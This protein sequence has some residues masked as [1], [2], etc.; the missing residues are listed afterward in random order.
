MNKHMTMRTCAVC[1]LICMLGA[2]VSCNSSHHYPSQLT[3]VDSLCEVRP[4]SAQ[5]LLQTLAKDT[6]TMREDARMYYKLLTIRA[7][8]KLYQPHTSDSLIRQLVNYYEHGGDPKLLPIAYYYAGSVYR[9][10]NDAPQALDY[11]QK[12]IDTTKDSIFND[13]KM[14]AYSQAGGLFLKQR[15]YNEALDM[16]HKAYHSSLLLNDSLK[17]VHALRFIGT[18]YRFKLESDSAKFYYEKALH[19][20]ERYNDSRILG[21]LYIQMAAYYNQ[22]KDYKQAKEY[23]NKARKHDIT[24]ERRTFWGVAAETFRGLEVID[25]ALYYNYK[26]VGENHLVARS[27]GYSNLTDIY[28]DQKDYPKAAKYI[29]EY[30][31]YS[32]SVNEYAGREAVA[33]M[34]ALYNYQLR[35][36]ENHELNTQINQ[37]KRNKNILLLCLLIGAIGLSLFCY[38]WKREKKLLI[39]RIQTFK[40]TILS[41]EQQ[42]TL[43]QKEIEDNKSIL[44]KQFM[45]LQEA[46]DHLQTT[47]G[48]KEQAIT[49]LHQE[50]RHL[51]AQLQERIEESKHDDPDI[52]YKRSSI[53]ATISNLLSKGKGLH[54]DEWDKLSEA[55]NEIYP[56]FRK[57]LYNY[58]QLS[59]VEYHTC[60]LIKAGY[61]PKEIS[62]LSNCSIKTVSSIRKRL[63][64]KVFKINDSPS[65]WDEFIRAL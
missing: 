2:L 16:F 20:A 35:E 29:K 40:S 34:N 23:L 22:V 43:A 53:Y 44:Q 28:I 10:L 46:N 48:T 17:T 9:D 18:T 12:A 31:L 65:R 30:R 21:S 49:E 37:E 59:N 63:L 42:K 58:Y 54:D 11:F 7:A 41:I 64:D 47:I 5:A 8:D 15:M 56:H 33:Q 57:N 24:V 60:L 55:I 25:S 14:A 32:D 19:I 39:Q 51:S 27:D 61:T 52:L 26:L 50:I 3:T 4:D 62:I 13:R 1:I 6:A 38:H 45:T 36:K